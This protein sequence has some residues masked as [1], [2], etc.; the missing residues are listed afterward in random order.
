MLFVDLLAFEWQLG[1]TGGD[2]LPARA[3]VLS[4]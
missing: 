1:V 4:G 2:E 3:V